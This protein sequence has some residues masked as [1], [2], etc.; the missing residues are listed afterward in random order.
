[1]QFLIVPGRLRRVT[2]VR[3]V[4]KIVMLEVLTVY[5]IT[6]AR[7]KQPANGSYGTTQLLL[8]TNVFCNNSYSG[9]SYGTKRRYS[10]GHYRYETLRIIAKTSSTMRK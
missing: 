9:V 2:N 6:T 3:C 10:Y 1:M 7:N 4:A 5:H 8:N